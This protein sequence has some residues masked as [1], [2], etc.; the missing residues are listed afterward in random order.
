VGVVGHRHGAGADASAAYRFQDGCGCRRFT[1]RGS[2]LGLFLRR[3]P[4]VPPCK[5]LLAARAAVEG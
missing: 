3:T 1:T 2:A 5:G 4:P